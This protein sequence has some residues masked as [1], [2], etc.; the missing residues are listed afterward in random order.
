MDD[1]LR[2]RGWS[3]HSSDN[4]NTNSLQQQR[5]RADTDLTCD[6]HDTLTSTDKI[7][8]LNNAFDD[9]TS[10]GDH[11]TQLARLQT[12]YIDTRADLN[13]DH[14]RLQ[15]D[16]MQTCAAAITRMSKPRP[17]DA[18]LIAMFDNSLPMSY[19]H[20]KQLARRTQ[21]TTF[22]A[23]Y[24]DYMENVRAEL[25]SRSSM[26]AAFGAVGGRPRH[27]LPTPPGAGGSNNNDRTNSNGRNNTHVCL[28]CG[29]KGHSRGECKKSKNKCKHCGAMHLTSFCTKA[30]RDHRRG[31]L[32]RG[33]LAMIERDVQRAADGI[34]KS[35]W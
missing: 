14:L 16:T 5:P 2:Q 29:A 27:F 6:T 32:S 28:N 17:D 24:S 15:Y 20:I 34:K 8:L 9:A 33:A 21:H 30:E 13:E 18:T 23:H 1:G 25:S 35:Y 26:P 22:L 12:S 10:E 31:E 4:D 19:T 3:I 7:H 11:A